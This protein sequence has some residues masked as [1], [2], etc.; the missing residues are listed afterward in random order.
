MAKFC[1]NCGSP[2]DDNANVCG[3]CG[4]P[5]DAQETPAA[6]VAAPAAGGVDVNAIIGKAL[7]PENRTKL[8]A[9]AGALVLV[10]II[11]FAAIIPNVGYKGALNKHIT[12]IEKEDAKAY[13]KTCG[14][15][16]VYEE[17][18]DEAEERYEDTIDTVY[19][20][21]KEEC[22]GDIKL[23][24]KITDKEKA[25]EDDIEELQDSLEWTIEFFDTSVD[26][27]EVKK[28]YNIELEITCKGDDD[29]ETYDAECQLVK[30][31]GK[32]I[33]YGLDIE[34]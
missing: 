22:G 29:K 25:D 16:I 3:N 26:D 1:G 15:V 20:N 21:F 19:D 2:S 5:F 10:L 30:V 17:Y 24:Y 28:A 8:F 27:V 13:Y 23:S 7:A 32:W 31:N 33:V 18:D 9:G 12:S 14:G 11:I 34:W 4:M 6:P